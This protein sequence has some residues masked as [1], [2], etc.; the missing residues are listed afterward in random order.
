MSSVD[1]WPASVNLQGV[2]KKVAPP[3]EKNL[4]TLWKMTLKM[5]L[6]VLVC[7]SQ[8]ICCNCLCVCL[9]VSGV[10][11]LMC[12]EINRPRKQL[13]SS[14]RNFSRTFVTIPSATEPGFVLSSVLTIILPTAAQ[15]AGIAVCR[16]CQWYNARL[17]CDTSVRHICTK[18]L[19]LSG[20][21]QS[22]DRISVA[23]LTKHG[24]RRLTM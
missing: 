9:V 5:V 3:Q 10:L 11:V 14:I 4:W 23:P 24:W 18:S 16:S 15:H 22:I 13:Q 7:F 19:V 1:H 17:Q 2:S 12:V 20:I 8:C 6:Y 21:N